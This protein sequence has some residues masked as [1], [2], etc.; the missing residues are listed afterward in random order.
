MAPVIRTTNE[1]AD[2]TV[3]II[4]VAE[5]ESANKEWMK[6]ARATDTCCVLGCLGIGN[7]NHF[8]YCAGH[9]AP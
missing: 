3:E 4:N 9:D 1:Y 2:G 8:P 7:Y 6:R 5:M